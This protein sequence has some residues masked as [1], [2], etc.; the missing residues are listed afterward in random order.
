M[1]R[2]CSMGWRRAFGVWLT[3]RWSAEGQAVASII[4]IV[5]VLI[6]FRLLIRWQG[7]ELEH[8]NL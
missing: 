8:M 3:R 6:A 7:W 4:A 1:D 5:V 2:G